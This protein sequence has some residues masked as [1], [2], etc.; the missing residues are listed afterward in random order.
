MLYILV[1]KGG[2]L[3]RKQL[4][5]RLEKVITIEKYKKLVKEI[6]KIK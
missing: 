5:R 1:L 6:E 2:G 3:H 4:T